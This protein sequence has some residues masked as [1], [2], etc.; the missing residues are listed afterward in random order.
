[1]ASFMVERERYHYLIVEDRLGLATAWVSPLHLSHWDDVTT[2]APQQPSA[3]CAGQ[4]R[5]AQERAG[6]DTA[7]PGPG[8]LS[9]PTFRPHPRAAR[10]AKPPTQAR[11]LH[12]SRPTREAGLA[13]TA[14]IAAETCADLSSATPWV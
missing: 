9:E 6:S 13:L 2:T 11:S 4:R 14:S 10:A 12:E 8:R 7:A 5:A 1:L 3:L